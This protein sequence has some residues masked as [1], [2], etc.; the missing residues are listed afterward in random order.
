VVVHDIDNEFRP[1][2]ITDVSSS[3][4]SSMDPSTYGSLIFISEYD[5]YGQSD[6]IY[7]EDILTHLIECGF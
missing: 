3:A 2:E 6:N 1:Q 7:K 5:F 4:F